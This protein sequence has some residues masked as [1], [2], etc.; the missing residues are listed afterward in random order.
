MNVAFLNIISKPSL[1]KVR[2][3]LLIINPTKFGEDRMKN[4][5]SYR[6]HKVFDY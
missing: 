6:V 5:P 2:I 4:D 1:N 3:Y